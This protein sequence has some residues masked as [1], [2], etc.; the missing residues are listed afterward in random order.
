MTY[1]FINNQSKTPLYLQIVESIKV[2]IEQKKLRH[3]DALP[4]ESQ[5]A[6]MFHIS[7][8]VV[9]QAYQLLKD[10]NLIQSVKGKGSFVFTRPKHT[11]NYGLFSV[12]NNQQFDK[13]PW[14]FT[15]I[16]KAQENIR[17][18]FRHEQSLTVLVLKRIASDGDFPM[19]YQRVY[20]KG[21]PFT[22]D[23]QIGKYTPLKTI[24]ALYFPLATWQINMT[25]QPEMATEEVALALNIAKQ[26]QIHTWRVSFTQGGQLHGIGYYHFPAAFISLK[27]SG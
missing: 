24:L 8:I 4:S 18:Q 27:R 19:L 12:T 6:Q 20:L 14:T 9:K 13:L 15:G 25:Y 17:L 11:L 10:M 5:I 2:A 3:L 1:F 23:S 16:Q 22:K 21:E 26:S 7:P